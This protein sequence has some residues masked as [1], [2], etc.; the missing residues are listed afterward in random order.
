ML[1]HLVPPFNKYDMPY[2]YL[3]LLYMKL[4]IRNS[5]NFHDTQKYNYI[6]RSHISV[7]LNQFLYSKGDIPVGMSPLLEF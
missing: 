4:S 1:L 2:S 5:L 3:L 6:Y 7:Y